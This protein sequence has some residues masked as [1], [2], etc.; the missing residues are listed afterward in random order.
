MQYRIH[1][2]H[3][4]PPLSNR[5]RGRHWSVAHKLRREAQEVLGVYARLQRVPAASCRRQVSLAVALA[6][7]QKQFDRDAVDKL[8]LDA[9]VGCGLLLDDGERGLAGRIEIS[10]SRCAL[11][12]WGTIL[13]L[14]DVEDTQA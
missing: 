1:I 3:W 8:L 4:R 6:P 12:D 11:P 9:L 10:F 2:P 13:T 5:Y 14:E 7:R